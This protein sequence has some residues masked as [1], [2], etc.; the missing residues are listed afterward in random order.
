MMESSL[1]RRKLM[2]RTDSANS[3]VRQHDAGLYID[4]DGISE[5]LL[6]K[7]RGT[8]AYRN[9]GAPGLYLTTN[10][11]KSLP[12]GCD[13]EV[14]TQKMGTV[15]GLA[16]AFGF[17]SGVLL[18]LPNNLFRGITMTMAFAAF[19]VPIFIKLH[20]FSRP[21]PDGLLPG[22]DTNVSF[23]EADADLADWV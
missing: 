18:L 5:E 6:P 20:P 10:M 21:H 13:P 19:I 4:V 11:P 22:A 17:I 1:A 15:G 7:T 8:D 23:S 2:F 3:F 12:F 16:S 14:S 9:I